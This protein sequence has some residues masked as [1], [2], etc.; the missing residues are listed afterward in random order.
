M[1]TSVLVVGAGPTGLALA[2]ALA[3]ADVPVEVVDRATGPAT[4]SR[5][6]GLQPRGIEVLDRIGAL[7]DLP[8]HGRAIEHTVVLVGGRQFADLRF[9]GAGPLVR[10]RAL[11]VSQTEIESRLRARFAELGGTIRWAAGATGLHQDATGVDVALADGSTVRAA[12]VVGC[13]GAHSAVREAAG[14]GFPG[15]PLNERFLLADVH[16]DLPIDRDSVTV[17]LEGDRMLAVF[18]LPGADLWRLMAPDRRPAG[19]HL[20]AADVRDAL[21]ALLESDAGIPRAAVGAAEWTSVFAIHRRLAD[22][23]RAGRVLLAGDA[24][25]VHSP[26]GGQGLN[27]GIGDAENLAWK[28]ALVASGLAGEQLL[29]TYQAERRPV[30]AEVLAAT[31][32]A[33]GV[34]LGDSAPARALRRLAVPLLD[35][36]VVQRALLERASQLRISYRHGPLGR[37]FGRGLRAG[38]RVP[39]LRCTRTDGTPTRLHAEL[40]DT[41]ALLC[42]AGLDDIRAAVAERLPVAVLRGSGRDALLVRPD[43]HLAWRGREPRGIAEWLTRALG[44]A[45][46]PRVGASAA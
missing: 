6:L 23:Y 26:F 8:E 22:T 9:A 30:A 36:D 5:A 11:I 41:W 35:H 20:A 24:A 1:N 27:T 28:L 21:A 29:D 14:I 17:W 19:G 4:T 46:A 38:D 45:V 15:V 12:W 31:S 43:G 13:D 44:P 40:G 39:D 34:A 18:P 2:C 3:A 7:G 16:A 10:R 42:P 32:A 25:H 33:T 37:R